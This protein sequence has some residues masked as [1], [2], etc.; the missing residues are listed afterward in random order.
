MIRWRLRA[1]TSSTFLVVTPPIDCATEPPG[2]ARRLT[3]RRLRS[4]CSSRWRQGSRRGS[5]T[6][7]H[8]SRP[9]SRRSWVCRRDTY[10]TVS[11]LLTSCSGSVPHR[12][13]QTIAPRSRAFTC[14][15]PRPIRAAACRE[16]RAI[17]RR[18][19]FAATGNACG[20][21]ESP[22]NL[23]RHSSG[24]PRTPQADQ[25]LKGPEMNVSADATWSR[26]D[27]RGQARIDL[28]A[29]HRLAARFGL[30]EGIDNH[31]TLMVPG[32]SDRFYLAP[33]GLHWSEVK[34]SDLLVLDFAGSVIG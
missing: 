34:A 31:L 28:A 30:N 4:M 13:G 19:R 20:P 22:Y 24:R 32:Y 5:S 7:R 8:S 12:T 17:T 11:S 29:C 21:I 9:I 14:V 25:A 16:F 23:A 15:V 6:S 18:V 3:L 2:G 27:A 1:S 10:S 33:F 26:G